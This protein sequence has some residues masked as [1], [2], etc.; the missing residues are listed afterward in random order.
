[1]DLRCQL[2]WVLDSQIYSMFLALVRTINFLKPNIQ[3][4]RT[5]SLIDV[6]FATLISLF[7]VL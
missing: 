4:V 1:M 2:Q 6:A 3:A 5:A 7:L